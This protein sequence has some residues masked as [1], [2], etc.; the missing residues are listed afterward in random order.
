MG[1]IE[2]A[3]KQLILAKYR[4]IREFSIDVDLPYS[5]IDTILKRG[6][7]NASVNNVI[8]ICK[9]LNISVDLL[10][11][12]II[13]KYENSNTNISPEEQ[14]L[15]L[16]YRSADEIDKTIVRRALNLEKNKE[17]AAPAKKTY[18]VAAMGNAN[19]QIDK[20]LARKI[21]EAAR[22]APDATDRDDLF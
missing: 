2:I 5:T 12:G 14:Q 21:A 10:A 8:K 9:T 15:I 7:L 19:M 22:N 13:G 20:D 16:A 17:N 18:R 11:Q 3:L 1:D 4:S 6:I